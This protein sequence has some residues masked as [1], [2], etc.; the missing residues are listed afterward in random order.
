MSSLRTLF[1]T[2]V[3]EASLAEERGFEALNAEL[4]DACRV[5]AVEDRAGRDW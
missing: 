4:L 1:A 2:R 5:L 3:Y